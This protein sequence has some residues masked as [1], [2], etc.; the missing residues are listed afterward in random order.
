[1]LCK[2]WFTPRWWTCEHLGTEPW[3]T[4]HLRQGCNPTKWAIKAPQIY[5]LQRN[6]AFLHHWKLT[7]PFSRY[8]Y[9]V[10]RFYIRRW[11]Y[12]PSRLHST[13]MKNKCKWLHLHL[14]CN[15]CRFAYNI[16]KILHSSPVSLVCQLSCNRLHTRKLLRTYWELRPHDFEL[17]GWQHLFTLYRCSTLGRRDTMILPIFLEIKRKFTKFWPWFSCMPTH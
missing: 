12:S 8:F 1:M 16:Y 6:R 17:E 10:I 4:A 9:T 3:L 5:S 2:P 15:L 13:V 14:N 11:A 7:G